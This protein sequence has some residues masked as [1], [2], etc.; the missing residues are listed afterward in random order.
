MPEKHLGL[1]RALGYPPLTPQKGSNLE[2]KAHPCM[3]QSSP[4]QTPPPQL[5]TQPPAGLGCPA[6]FD[7][8]TTPHYP[9]F[10]SV[11]QTGNQAF[12]YPSILSL[13]K[14]N[15]LCGIIEWVPV[16]LNYIGTFVCLNNCTGFHN[17]YL[18]NC[19]VKYISRAFVNA[20]FRAFIQVQCVV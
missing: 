9:W 10:R 11:K 8:H 15:S 13:K 12:T 3:Q 2:V 19:L 17:A 1:S 20:P 6:V 18:R 4:L 5:K 7:T 14:I 16:S